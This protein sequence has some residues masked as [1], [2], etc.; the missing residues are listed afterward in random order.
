MI[1]HFWLQ[2]GMAA[3]AFALAAIALLARR[4][5]RE[6]LKAAGIMVPVSIVF[7]APFTAR[8]GDLRPAMALLFCLLI[9]TSIAL[10]VELQRRKS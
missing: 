8:A 5:S 10:F 1:T 9:A 3:A 4:F 6:Q 2:A 7:L